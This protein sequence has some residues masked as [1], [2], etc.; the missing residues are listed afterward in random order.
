MYYH[1]VKANGNTIQ[2]GI[3]EE[4][5]SN[6]FRPNLTQPNQRNQVGSECASIRGRDI[7]EFYADPVSFPSRPLFFS[8]EI[9]FAYIIYALGARPLLSALKQLRR[10]VSHCIDSPD[11]AGRSIECPLTTSELGRRSYCLR[12][13][14]RN[15]S[16]SSFRFNGFF[17]RIPRFSPGSFLMWCCQ[18]FSKT[19][20]IILKSRYGRSLRCRADVMVVVV[21]TPMLVV[22]GPQRPRRQLEES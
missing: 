5:S 12:A 20:D 11:E 1:A 9:L 13:R 2:A 19:K 7:R 21:A 15:P 22:D 3:D 10:H 16:G 17:S 8:R 14:Q 18:T 4:E 6:E